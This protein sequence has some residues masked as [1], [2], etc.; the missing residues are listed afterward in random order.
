M[1]SGTNFLFPNHPSPA[2]HLRLECILFSFGLH[3]ARNLAKAV[4]KQKGRESLSRRVQRVLAFTALHRSDLEFEF[5]YFF[6]F[7]SRLV[8]T[9]LGS[10]DHGHPGG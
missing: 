8:L 10:L 7:S 5:L 6:A 4:I 1:V 3:K 2:F 9:S